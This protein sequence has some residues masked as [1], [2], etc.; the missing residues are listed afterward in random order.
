MDEKYGK[1]VKN[2][3]VSQQSTNIHEVDVTITVLTILYILHIA[4]YI[5]I[6]MPAAIYALDV[7]FLFILL[8]LQC[9]KFGSLFR[10][11][12]PFVTIPL[13]NILLRD[14]VPTNIIDVLKLLSGTF[15]IWIYPLLSLYLIKKNNVNLAKSIFF[16]YALVI[17]I[18]GITSVIACQD[19]P[20]IIRMNPGDLRGEDEVMYQLKMN[21]N[22]G[23][24]NNIYEYV[25]LMPVVVMVYKWSPFF[26]KGRFLR[27]ASITLA[28]FMYYV[29]FTSQFMTA[30]IVATL[31]LLLIFAPINM[32]KRTFIYSFVTLFLLFFVV[33][34]SIPP[35]LHSV[36]NNYAGETMAERLEH[37][38]LA[39]EGRE[40]DID[41]GSDFEEREKVYNRSYQTI[42]EYNIVGCWDHART[43]GHSFILDN[44]AKYGLLGFLLMYF[45]FKYVL[46]RYVLIYKSRSWVYFYYYGFVIAGILCYINPSGFYPQMYFVYPISA[47]LFEQILYRKSFL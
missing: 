9:Q 38:A 42:I 43:G 25:L 22:V 16:I 23:D 7:F 29:I 44:I 8:F 39:L 3:F 21:M 19:I 14:G 36:A 2:M 13:L 47:Y 41:E 35:L 45:M 18:V 28:F 32:N 1:K 11:L 26:K 10:Y 5:A 33:K 31:S 20:L 37:V 6:H 4:P 34:A 24:F 17:T 27:I 30:T 12:A 46:E 15:Q 40:A